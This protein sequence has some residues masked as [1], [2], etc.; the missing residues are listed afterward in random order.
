MKKLAILSVLAV[1]AAAS[2]HAQSY[3]DLSYVHTKLKDTGTH[4]SGNPA[5]LRAIIGY[6]FH[7]NLSVEAMLA[8]GIRSDRITLSDG[9]SVVLKNKSSLGLFLR[10]QV[11]LGDKFQAFARIGV[12][13]S[14][15]AFEN[16]TETTRLKGSRI[17]YGLGASYR[18]TQSL[19]LTAD[20]MHYFR[21]DEVDSRGLAIGIAYRF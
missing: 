10:P 9:E 8:T 17:A 16:Q 13:R 3:V 15:F 19:S 1:A 20:F 6:E 2:A 5:S 11:D 21:K 4:E 7:P 12:V 14:S 18:L